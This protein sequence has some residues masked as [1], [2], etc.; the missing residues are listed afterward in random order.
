[1]RGIIMF[2]KISL[3]FTALVL[4]LSTVGSAYAV[5]LK[6]SHQWPGTPRADGSFDPRH[7]MVQIIAD[8]VKK[9]NVDIDIRIYPAKSLYKPKE[10]WKP[11]T[12]GQPNSEPTVDKTKTNAVKYKDIFLNIIFPLFSYFN[13]AYN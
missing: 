11:M 10:Q 1:M 7:E 4:V 13:D 8:E 3:Y 5:T 6:A 2:K 9:A 12:T